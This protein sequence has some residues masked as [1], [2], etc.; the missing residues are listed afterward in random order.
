MWNGEK[1]LGGGGEK[2][3]IK[4]PIQGF[5]INHEPVKNWDERVRRNEKIALAL[6]E[7]CKSEEDF[8]L[9]DFKSVFEI[10]EES[11]VF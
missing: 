1:I 7:M 10:V 2:V 5:A 11:I 8:R 6:V 4:I 3:S 9:S